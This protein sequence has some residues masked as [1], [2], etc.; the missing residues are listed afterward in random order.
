MKTIEPTSNG[1]KIIV[2]VVPNASK[3]EIT[4][5]IGDRLKV[6]VKSPPES[7]KANKAVCKLIAGVLHLNVRQV[8]ICSGNTTQ[9][10]TVEIIDISFTT[11]AEKL[12]LK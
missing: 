9:I 10:K 3:D 4:G 7:G 1:V 12:G 8:T 6:R 2:K 5:L 11:V